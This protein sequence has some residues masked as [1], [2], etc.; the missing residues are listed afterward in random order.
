MDLNKSLQYGYL[1]E[2][3]S[4]AF[5][6]TSFASMASSVINSHIGKAPWTEPAKHSLARAGNKRRLLEIPNPISQALLVSAFAKHWPLLRKRTGASQISVTRPL[7]SKKGE[8]LTPNRAMSERAGI[9]ARCMPG[10]RFTLVTDISQFYP[11]IYTHAVDWAIHSKKTA[12]SD[13]RGV[14]A[15][16]AI[17]KMLQS[18]RYG[19]TSGVSIGPETSWLVAELVMSSVDRS[20]ISKYGSIRI[21]ERGFRALDDIRIYTES[22]GQAEDILSS[23]QGMLA[24]FELSLHPEKSTIMDGLHL[25]GDSWAHDLRSM[26]LRDLS[27]HA[28]AN[29][30]MAIFARAFEIASEDPTRG[31]LSYAI[32]R[33]N[34]FPEGPVGW[35]LFLNFLLASLGQES[36]TYRTVYEILR[37]AQSRELPIDRDHLSQ[38]LNTEI[39]RH[40]PHNRGYE[41]AWAMTLMREFHLELDPKTA[42]LISEMDDNPSLILLFDIAQNQSNIMDESIL[43]AA[44]KRAAAPDALK[45]SDWLLAYHL[46]HHRIIRQRKPWDA[47]PLFEKLDNS[48]VSFLVDAATTNS[49]AKMRRKRPAF[50]LTTY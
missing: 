47:F 37:Y 5:E 35:P 21:A 19:Q 31:A 42:K 46:R 29:D 20:L 17:D 7:L 36:S 24:E 6:S 22:R 1:P 12:K 2:Q 26:P 34:P 8:S 14:R 4:A 45:S 40:A 10:S 30:I 9:A 41:V 33:C 44:R 11:S 3:L 18:A 13:L 32:K 50:A 27:D 25:P 38:F 23:Y 28:Q 43:G 39:A 49:R 15:G 16:S 48:Q